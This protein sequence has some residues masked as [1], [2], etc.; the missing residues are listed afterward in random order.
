ML[1]DSGVEKGRVDIPPMRLD[2]VCVQLDQQ[3]RCSKGHL[4][5]TP[6][7]RAEDIGAFP[8]GFFFSKLKLKRYSRVSWRKL[9][10]LI[11]DI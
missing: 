3:W 9:S 11:G 5:K 1:K 7:E 2:I 8:N 4:G 6:R 10:C